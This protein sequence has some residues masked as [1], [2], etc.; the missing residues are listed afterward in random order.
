MCLILYQKTQNT[1]QKIF[2]HLHNMCIA[3]SPPPKK[4][5]GSGIEPV[6]RT[7]PVCRI[8]LKNVDVKNSQK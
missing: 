1:L 8:F 2:D 4:P 5:L 6:I 3:D 7:R